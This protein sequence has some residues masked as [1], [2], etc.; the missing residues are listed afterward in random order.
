[1]KKIVKAYY[2]MFYKLYKWYE[3]GPSVWL[4]DWKALL[5]LDVLWIFIGISGLVYYTLF[6]DRYFS[7][8]DGKFFLIGYIVLI[9]IPN[10]FIFHHR[11]QWKDIVKEFDKLPKGKNRLGGWLVFLI[12]MLIIG[13]M[14]YAFYLMSQVD[15]AQYR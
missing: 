15:W 10:Y 1:M 8:G 14:V 9:G 7:I 13:N 3:R 2:Y 12:S 11:D 5:S 6:A 4:S